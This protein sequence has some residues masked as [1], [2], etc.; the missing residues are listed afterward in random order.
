MIGKLKGIVDTIG[1]D[2]ILLD[3]GG[4]CYNVYF[5][6]K[7][8]QTLVPEQPIS[9]WIS[10]II[11]EDDSLLYG[12]F[13]LSTKAWFRELIKL[14]GISGK[15]AMNILGQLS[16]K[17]LEDS[18][19]TDNAEL[20]ESVSGIGKKIASRI[21]NELSNAP[22]KVLQFIISHRPQ[23]NQQSA[24]AKNHDSDSASI[25]DNKT[26]DT[27]YLSQV[28]EALYGLGYHRSKA[29]DAAQKAIRQQHEDERD[30]ATLIKA[31]LQEIR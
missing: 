18:I 31:A 1:S 9:I 22:K 14:N 7:D 10:H 8:L 12:F 23:G 21:V 2:Y 3:V 27:H 11:K 20:F 29:L 25:A 19:N 28:V 6:M 4:V 30:I 17:D 13:D 15:T 24:C 26:S 16:I 5:S